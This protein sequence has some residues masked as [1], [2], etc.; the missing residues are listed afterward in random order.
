MSII[1]R[2]FTFTVVQLRRTTRNAIKPFFFFQL[3]AQQFV[4]AP[5]SYFSLHS[6]VPQERPAILKRISER[7]GNHL[8]YIEVD[9]IIAQVE[10]LLAAIAWAI[11]LV[12]SSVVLCGAVLLRLCFRNLSIEHSHDMRLLQLLGVSE[13]F[14]TKS[15]RLVL[16]YPLMVAT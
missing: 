6:I 10:E 16:L 5:K 2:E 7:V 4:T 13:L 3:P 14:I 15:S 8:S 9:E 12:L 11:V 1:G